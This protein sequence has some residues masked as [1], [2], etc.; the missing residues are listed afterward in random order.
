MS[1]KSVPMQDVRGFLEPEEVRA[2]IQSADFGIKGGRNRILIETL[3]KTG[4]RISEVVGKK[5]CQKCDLPSHYAV[6]YVDG[7]RKESPHCTCDEPDYFHE[8][9]LVPDRL[10][11]DETTIILYT[12]KRNNPIPRRIKVTTSL[13]EDIID[14]V[15]SKNIGL[16]ERIFDITQERVRQIVKKAGKLAGVGKVGE[17]LPHP[18]IFRH[19]HAIAY[20]REDNSM[21]GLRNLQKRFKHSNIMTTAH[22]LQFARTGEQKKVEEIFG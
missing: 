22:Y 10:L 14:Y 13:M 2:L 5:I 21:E 16:E 17:S 6:Y 15:E 8:H 3:W 1:E 11:S 12:R 9:P 19:S 20:I 18:H 4:S 7:E